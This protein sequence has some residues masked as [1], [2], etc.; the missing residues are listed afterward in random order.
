MQ[1]LKRI[2]TLAATMIVAAA[3]AGC[4]TIEG[5]GQDIERAGDEIEDATGS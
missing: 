1:R 2:R 5:V 4:N 3:C